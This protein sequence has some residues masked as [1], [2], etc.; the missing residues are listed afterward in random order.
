VG[1]NSYSAT[2][3]SCLSNSVSCSGSP[4]I[5]SGCSD[6]CVAYYSAF[7]CSTINGCTNLCSWSNGSATQVCLSSL[8]R[9]FAACLSC[10]AVSGTPQTFAA[11]NN[12]ALIN[13]YP[14][15][16]SRTCAYPGC[17]C[18]QSNCQA[19]CTYNP[20]VG[21][22]NPFFQITTATMSQY[23]CWDPYQ[24]LT[25]PVVLNYSQPS[26]VTYTFRLSQVCGGFTAA[27]LNH[28]CA[29]YGFDTNAL[30]FTLGC[31]SVLVTLSCLG[32][33]VAAADAYCTNFISTLSNPQTPLYNVLRPQTIY[34]ATAPGDNNVWLYSLF[35][36][37]LLIPLLCIAL[38]LCMRTRNRARESDARGASSWTGAEAEAEPQPHTLAL[39]EPHERQPPLWQQYVVPTAGD[40]EGEIQPYQHV[41]AHPQYAVAE[42]YVSHTGV[43]K[44]EEEMH[45]HNMADINQ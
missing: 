35:A 20:V 39:V 15:N 7:Y 11:A 45:L 21:C 38:W 30:K 16:V 27:D 33:T 26:N 10:G 9:L 23:A 32:R 19:D 12:L 4:S 43:K 25:D 3:G 14:Y 34:T 18:T 37:L 40:H 41:V 2:N 17:K 42:G 8:D 29:L 1:D 36:L 5:P 44:P 6:A 22:V 13:D 31:G 24:A 28:Y